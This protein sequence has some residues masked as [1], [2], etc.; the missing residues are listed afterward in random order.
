MANTIWSIV[1]ALGALIV[2]GGVMYY[3]LVEGDDRVRD[4]EARSF[5]DEHGHWPD[6]PPRA[7]IRPD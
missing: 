6:E 4:E 1:A 3:W 7:E 2:V 5:F